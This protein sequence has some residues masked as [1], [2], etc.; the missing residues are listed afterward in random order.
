MKH[1]LFYVIA[2]TLVAVWAISTYMGDI[3]GRV[4]NVLPLIAAAIIFY[5]LITTGPGGYRRSGLRP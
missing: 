3:P 4:S 5:K 1:Y 2:A